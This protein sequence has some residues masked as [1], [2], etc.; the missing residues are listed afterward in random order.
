MRVC[1]RQLKIQNFTATAQSGAPIAG[2]D[3]FRLR[4]TMNAEG[5]R[6]YEIVPMT[7]A[8]LAP[9]L[10]LW[11]EQF[12]RHL[13]GVFPDFFPGGEEAARACLLDQIERGNALAAE[14]DGCLA[15][16]MAWLYFD[17]HREPSA[18]CPTVGH[19]AL[20]G[21]EEGV[22]RALYMEAS[23]RWVA[24]GK[25]NHLWMTYHDDIVLKD[26][27]YELGF[28]A[29]VIDA[30]RRVEPPVEKSNGPFRIT[31]AGEGDAD[32]LL[33]LAGETSAYY[34]DAPLF[35]RRKRFSPGDIRDILQNHR[36][37]LAWDGGRLIGAL[38]F[39]LNPGFDCEQ[40]TGGLSALITGIGAY[41]DPAYR[42][43]GAG[44]QLVARMFQICAEIGKPWAHVCYE[45]ANP[46]ASGFWP[47]TFRPAIRSVR[48]T[49]NKD[50]NG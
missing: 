3:F 20:P 13:G 15:G 21:G 44:S 45:S 19:A 1:E 14:R 2:L 16:Y 48:R 35:L 46:F 10:A 22:Y 25:F 41:V 31:E 7:K 39:T 4:D 24:D 43:K 38:D 47:R 6:V 50:A 27:L 34:L 29:H 37:L 9:A 23:R 12:L 32:A 8:H 11:H 40:L 17:F 18:F 5:M 42:G 28:G 33:R 30:C 26:A 36:V 49:I